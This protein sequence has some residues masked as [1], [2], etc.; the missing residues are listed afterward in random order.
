MELDKIE[1]GEYVRTSQGHIAKLINYEP[2]LM[3]CTF[4]RTI[5]KNSY[6]P[7]KLIYLKD[8][9]KRKPEH[10]KNILDLLKDGDL[11]VVE[12]L[13]TPKEGTNKIKKIVI[14]EIMTLDVIKNC[15]QDKLFK[16]KHI[17]T[18]ERIEA[19]QID[20]ED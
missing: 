1:I 20:L 5:I 4:D 18:Q 14:C 10:S 8:L 19:T 9:L 16:I 6:V 11:I 15:V 7:S 13:Y 17:T 2:I 3:T 12:L